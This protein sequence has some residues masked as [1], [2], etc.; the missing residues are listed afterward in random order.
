MDFYT[1]L[2]LAP[3]AS[4][5]DVKRA[6]RR[7]SRRY[8]PGIN[9]GDRE[10]EALFRQ[11]TEAYETLVDAERRHRYETTGRAGTAADPPFEFAGFDF[12]VKAHGAQAAT[13]SELFAEALHPVPTPERGKPQPGAD[14]HA[15]LTVGFGEAMTGVDRQLMVTRQVACGAC[16]GAGSV[17]TADAACAHCQGAGKVR[18]ARGHMVFT[19]GCQAC[20]ATGRERHR[21]CGACAG[22]GRAV[23]TEAILVKVPAG[24]SDGTQLRVPERGHAG[25]FGGR[26]GDL[27]LDI[28]VRPHPVLRRDG[29]DLHMT[30]PVAVHEAALG[31][32]IE[33]PSFDG[34][35]R[36]KVPAG[37]QGGQRFRVRGRGAPT[38]TGGRGDLLVEVQLV[39]PPIGDERSK[40]LMREFARLHPAD[41]RAG[42]TTRF[43]S[44]S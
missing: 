28:R 8:H 16:G 29:D 17:R 25:A 30:V 33:V 10:A 35:V 42:L 4:V 9:P 1:L 5:T 11:I 2:G 37:T 15:V 7:L 32:R 34:P 14:V 22:Q 23:R 21:R 31:A 20:G 36:L 12:S 41:V 44:E 19:K 39:L 27:Y 6:Y 24:V 43:D 18:W 38:M 3:G 26:P 40:E 13:F